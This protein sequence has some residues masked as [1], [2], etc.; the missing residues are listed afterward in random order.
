MSP[1]Y[2]LGT[3]LLAEELSAVAGTSGYSI[4]AFVENLDREKAGGVLLDRPILWVDDLPVGAPCICALSTTRRRV[5]IEQVASRASFVT[6]VHPSSVILPRTDLGAGTVVSTGVLVGSNTRIGQHVFLNRGAR[7]GHHTRIGDYVTIQPGANIAG[8]IEI[9]D[10][11]YIGMGAIVT[12]RLTIGRGVTIAA[13][14]L[15]RHDVPDHAL[16]AGS[17]AVVKKRDVT[18]H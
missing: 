8:A 4:E 3:G 9:G 14:S 7:V 10:E 12:E 1:L 2:V 5:Y 11:T 17:P 6:L 18:P 13:G 15:V 16:V